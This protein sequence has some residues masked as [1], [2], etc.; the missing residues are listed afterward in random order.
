MHV[1]V[2]RQVDGEFDWAAAARDEVAAAKD[3]DA[4]DDDDKD[5]DEDNEHND[6]AEEEETGDDEDDGSDDDDGGDD[7]KE[8]DK[9][10][11]EEKETSM[12]GEAVIAVKAAFL[13]SLTCIRAEQDQAW[14]D[15][16][17][18]KSPPFHEN[19][20]ICFEPF[21]RLVHSI[22]QE[23]S[24]KWGSGRVEGGGASLPTFVEPLAI[25][26]NTNCFPGCSVVCRSSHVSS[27]ESQFVALIPLLTRDRSFPCPPPPPLL[28]SSL[29]AQI[30]LE[31]LQTFMIRLL[32][33]ALA[34]A[35]SAERAVVL[36]D[37]L[38]GAV[39]PYF[40]STSSDRS[41][42]DARARKIA[43]EIRAKKELGEKKKL[44][45]EVAVLTVQLQELTSKLAER[46][47]AAGE[48]VEGEEGKAEKEAES[49]DG[50]SAE[51]ASD[52][53]GYCSAKFWQGNSGNLCTLCRKVSYCNAA[54]QR[55]A[56]K[57]HKKDCRATAAAAAAT[58]AT[59]VRA[60]N[61]PSG[62]VN[63]EL[64]QLRAENVRLQ[65]ERA[66]QAEA[67]EN[68]QER[69]EK[70]VLKHAAAISATEHLAEMAISASTAAATA[71]ATATDGVEEKE[72]REDGDEGGDTPQREQRELASDTHAATALASA[73][74]APTSPTKKVRSRTCH[75]CSS[76]SEETMMA[77]SRCGSVRYCSL[78]CQRTDWPDHKAA[79]R[80]KAKKLREA[81]AVAAPVVMQSE[82]KSESAG[83]PSGTGEYDEETELARVLA[84]SINE[85]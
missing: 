10:D 55:K 71:A 61:D 12:S 74:F 70:L 2:G 69:N 26:V 6:E 56:W 4:N 49:T 39:N 64:E 67:L 45:D 47:R 42:H 73:P 31:K 16:T 36:L 19:Q 17:K 84:M 13:E 76:V 66:E 46:E 63:K 51:E 21:S 62:P 3:M 11:E 58:A 54:C 33:T 5:D 35:I 18:G 9:E 81:A 1:V 30:V 82:E 52:I 37:D 75:V 27:V 83:S 68:A 44:E 78:A 79:C 53:C 14:G 15:R 60:K 22:A 41:S 85:Q 20:F 34:R 32:E 29:L 8:S 72:H 24:K 57:R 40:G 80:E 48:S 65:R 50:D 38:E 23:V 25:Q 59:R 77:C 43:E 7:D 28:S